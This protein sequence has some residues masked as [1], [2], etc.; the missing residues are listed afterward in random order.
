MEWGVSSVGKLYL[1][2]SGWNYKHWTDGVFYPKGL[3]SSDWLDFYARHFD[4]VEVNNTFYGLPEKSVFESWRSTAPPGFV[5]T[6]KASR[7]FTH[8]KRLMD[9]ET[10]V[11]LFLSRAVGLADKLS[12]ILFQLPP[13]FDYQPE[14]L[15]ALLSFM[16]WQQTIP[17]VRCALEV[18]DQRWKNTDCFA[19]LQAHNWSWVLADKP[20][21]SLDGPVTADFVFLRRHGPGGDHGVNYTE[22][23]LQADALRVQRWLS[24]GRDV[25]LYYNN[26]IG[27]Y[28]IQNAL[29]IKKL[30]NEKME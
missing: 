16:D 17:G 5:F 28:A 11:D 13:Q 12:C 6:I 1:G 9:P 3:K 8:I 14:R 19:R 4:T 10:H 26:D 18:R 20:G 30:L 2:T 23:M 21:F 25:Y 15:E 7:H 22:E 27:G 24:E 29:H